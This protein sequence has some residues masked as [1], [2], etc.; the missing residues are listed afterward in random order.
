MPYE[1][2]CSI[3]DGFS[4]SGDLADE[5]YDELVRSGG[6]IAGHIVQFSKVRI[7]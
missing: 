1:L 3:E 5:L 7:V 2:V 4:R 6:F